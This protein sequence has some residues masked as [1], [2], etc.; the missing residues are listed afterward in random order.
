[1]ALLSAH[2]WP[3]EAAL[4][5]NLKVLPEETRDCVG[6]IELW[7]SWNGSQLRRLKASTLWDD[8]GAPG[9]GLMGRRVQEDGVD[10]ALFKEHLH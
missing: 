1:M 4:K 8:T 10:P 9:R 7:S 2:P 3:S 5:L 6:A